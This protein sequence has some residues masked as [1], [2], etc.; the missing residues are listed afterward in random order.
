MVVLV[1]SDLKAA[2][3]RIRVAREPLEVLPGRAALQYLR[4]KKEKMGHLL[5][6]V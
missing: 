1:F 6:A 4:T 3:W 2:A 5:E